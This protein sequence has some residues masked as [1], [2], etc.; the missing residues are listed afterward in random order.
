MSE[1]LVNKWQEPWR[2]GAQFNMHGRDASSTLAFCSAQGRL[3][4]NADTCG[5]HRAGGH[6][7]LQLELTLHGNKSPQ[8]AFA[9]YGFDVLVVRT[10]CFLCTFSQCKGWKHAW[11]CAK[12]ISSQKECCEQALNIF[13]SVVSVS[14]GSLAGTSKSSPF[15]ANPDTTTVRHADL[16]QTKELKFPRSCPVL[17]P[18][19]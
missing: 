17:T 1:Q 13:E 12:G 3:R 18:A 15:F 7:Q 16:D 10:R 14:I 8:R 9:C 6:L 11:V 5:E 19:R 4:H 2:N